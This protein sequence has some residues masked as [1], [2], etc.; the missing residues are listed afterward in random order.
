MPRLSLLRILEDAD[1]ELYEDGV[2]L[3]SVEFDSIAG[4]FVRPDDRELDADA[5][6]FKP[7]DAEAFGLAEL[8]VDGAPGLPV[9]SAKR[10]PI[11][12]VSESYA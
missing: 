7:L 3:A 8:G 10:S 2:D 9:I 11:G 6:R 1:A 4:F 12:M 5:L